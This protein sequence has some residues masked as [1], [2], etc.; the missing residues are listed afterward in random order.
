MIG[1]YDFRSSPH[2][3]L[4]LFL[5]RLLAK[6]GSAHPQRCTTPP[7]TSHDSVPH[8]TVSTSADITKAPW[9]ELPSSLER[10][11]SSDG[12]SAAAMAAAATAAAATAATAAADGGGDG[13][14]FPPGAFERRASA[15]A[16]STD[17]QVYTHTYA[18]VACDGCWAMPRLMLML[19]FAGCL[20]RAGPHM[21]SS[22]PHSVRRPFDPHESKPARVSGRRVGAHIVFPVRERRPEGNSFD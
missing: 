1:R 22:A 18:S 4:W 5:S 19:A 10:G 15:S 13:G 14:V 3:R 9:E 7:D 2:R 6:H 17:G 12:G 21:R 11:E 16:F 20:R 8:D